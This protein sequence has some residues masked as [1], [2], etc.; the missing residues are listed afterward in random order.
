MYASAATDDGKY[1]YVNDYFLKNGLFF[2]IMIMGHVVLVERHEHISKNDYYYLFPC[3]IYYPD[4]S[5]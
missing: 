5:L 4:H 1:I 2:I 3:K